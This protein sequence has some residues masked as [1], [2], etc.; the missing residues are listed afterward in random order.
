MIYHVGQAT[1]L[2]GDPE[3]R[4]GARRSRGRDRF[5]SQTPT[6][7]QLHAPQPIAA[8]ETHESRDTRK[9]EAEP[10]QGPSGELALLLRGMEEIQ[11]RQTEKIIGAI[12]QASG[13]GQR[14]L[15]ANSHAMERVGVFVDV[16]NLLYA[17]RYLNRWID[18]GRLLDRLVDGRRLVRAQAYSP[19]DPDPNADQSFFNP[20]KAQG[21]RVTTKNYRTFSSG[22]KKADMD[23]DMCMDIVRIVNAGAV[24]CVVLASGDGDFLPLLEY[25][26]DH[27]VRVEIA[28]FNESTHEELKSACDRF[29]NL[30]AMDASPARR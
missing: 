25:C 4:N 30:T 23:L 28:A 26:Y 13:N 3:S 8:I 12:A 14:N 9:P 19:T 5:G 10:V 22:A 20:V 17:A 29:I 15:A 18:F 16:A 21:Y 1:Q 6:T 27:G 2:Q 24:D 11:A 7:S